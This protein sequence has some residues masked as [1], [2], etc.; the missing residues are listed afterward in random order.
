VSEAAMVSDD[1]VSLLF[2]GMEKLGPGDN[3]HTLRV[4]RLLPKR[5][6]RLVIDAGCG[7]GRQTLVLTKELGTLI[8]AVD[9]SEPFLG[10]LVQRAGE[11][12]VGQLVRAHHMDMKDIPQVFHGIDLL[13]SE[14]SAYNIGF[15]NALATWAPA[16]APG[17]FVVVSELS[18]LTE[19]PPYEVREF[20]RSCY[21]DMRSVPQNVAIANQAGYQ[22]LATHTLPREAWVDGFYD[23]L[24][25]RARA[26]LGHPAPP[27][28]SFAA[29][30]VREIEI[31]RC[32]DDS[33]GY[34][35]FVL[36]RCFGR[37]T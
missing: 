1:P 7:T 27:V 24:E 12:G 10:E 23:T 19:Q 3:D 36:Q 9:C 6:F 15:P 11:A 18:W 26:L 25:P 31:F 35:F 30:T 21:P 4:L 5:E 33:Y 29:E 28:Q 34:V 16:L 32:S 37:A 17:G 20:F 13:W 14:G 2:S 22:V 8:H